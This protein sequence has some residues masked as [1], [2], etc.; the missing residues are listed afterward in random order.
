[1]VLQFQL[2]K[3]GTNAL[4][5]ALQFQLFKKGTKAKKEPKLKRWYSKICQSVGVQFQFLKKEPKAKNEY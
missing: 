5:L 2:F 4:A 3:K 1:M